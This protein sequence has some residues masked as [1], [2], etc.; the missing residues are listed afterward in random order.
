MSSPPK[1]VSL[2]PRAGIKEAVG[3][4]STGETMAHAALVIAQQYIADTAADS[5]EAIAIINAVDGLFDD[6]IESNVG[7]RHIIVFPVAWEADF[8]P[9]ETIRI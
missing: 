7:F 5:T 8:K 1:T 4:V 3:F 9:P 6:L 2:S